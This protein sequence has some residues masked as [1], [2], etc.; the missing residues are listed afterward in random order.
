[1][2][3]ARFEASQE[4]E[5]DETFLPDG[6]ISFSNP[7]YNQMTNISSSSGSSSANST[8]IHSNGG[9]SNGSSSSKLNY[10]KLSNS[11]PDDSPLPAKK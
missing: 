10:Q 9:S 6:R 7:W 11:E 4:E 2:S 5:D 1:M 8:G 3:S